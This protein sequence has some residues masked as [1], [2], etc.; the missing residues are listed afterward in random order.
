MMGLAHCSMGSP[1]SL[2]IPFA[3]L[4]ERERRKA[5]RLHVRADREHFAREV[6]VARM[7]PLLRRH[8]RDDPARHLV[9]DGG[10]QRDLAGGAEQATTERVRLARE[11]DELDGAADCD[12]V[13]R[14]LVPSRRH[15]AVYVRVRRKLT[16]ADPRP[17]QRDEPGAIASWRERGA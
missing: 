12:V 2:R 8:D 14:D 6:G 13:V 4:V 1:S 17:V 11:H 9:A 5:E 16:E 15:R 10:A 7:R 3:L